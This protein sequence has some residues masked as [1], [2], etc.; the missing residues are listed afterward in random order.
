MKWRI[1]PKEFEM[2]SSKN[3]KGPI[4]WSATPDG[5][6]PYPA[7]KRKLPKKRRVMPVPKP[8]PPKGK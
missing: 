2:S 3:K 7:A 8:K 4:D 5:S 1:A 6:N